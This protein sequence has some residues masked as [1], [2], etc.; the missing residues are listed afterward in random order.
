MGEY[1]TLTPTTFFIGNLAMGDNGGTTA[2][3]YPRVGLYF[4]P[5]FLPN[6]WHINFKNYTVDHRVLEVFL[7]KYCFAL[8]SREVPT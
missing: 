3:I 8:L 5:I 7:K 1:R 2:E 6:F 4:G